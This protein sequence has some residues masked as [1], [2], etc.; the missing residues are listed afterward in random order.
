MRAASVFFVKE[1]GPRATEVSP[2][3]DHHRER[4]GALLLTSGNALGGLA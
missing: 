2:F 4:F 1:L 3:I